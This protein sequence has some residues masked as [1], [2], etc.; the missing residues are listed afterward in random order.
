MSTT[1]T[2]SAN[3]TGDTSWQTVC[4][5]EEIHENIGV[6]ALVGEN[7]QAAIFKVKDKFYAISNL[8]PFS[9]AA[10]ISRGLICNIKG[11]LCVASPIF[12]QHFCLMSGTCLEDNSVQLK[13]YALRVNGSIL[14]IQ[15]T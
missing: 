7:E 6:C 8:D 3:L 2:E 5:I 11:S 13:T 1:A 4:P 15:N 9:D 12:K 14:E 10:V